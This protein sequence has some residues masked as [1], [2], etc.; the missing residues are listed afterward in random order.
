MLKISGQNF[1][2][3]DSQEIKLDDKH[4]ESFWF[5]AV[6]FNFKGIRNSFDDSTRCSS[7]CSI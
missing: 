7:I 3:D 6:L 2:A 4:N 5:W 1:M